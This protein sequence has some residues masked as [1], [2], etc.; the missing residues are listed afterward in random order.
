[1]LRLTIEA[2]A[3][4]LGRICRGATKPGYPILSKAK[5][6]D[7]A[8]TRPQNGHSSENLHFFLSWGILDLQRNRVAKMFELPSVVAFDL[9]G[10]GAFEVIRADSDSISFAAGRVNNISARIR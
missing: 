6:G 9:L 1:M 8:N 5:G 3:C 10:S 2:L 4:A 7:T